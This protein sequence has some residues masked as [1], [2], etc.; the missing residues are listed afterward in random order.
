MTYSLC[1]VLPFTLR[2]SVPYFSGDSIVNSERS[3]SLLPRFVLANVPAGIVRRY[4]SPAT[5]GALSVH[6]RSLAVS[7]T[8]ETFTG[9]ELSPSPRRCRSMAVLSTRV[10][11]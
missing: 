2:I 8:K 1:G 10:N 4:F 5:Q 9:S 11:G 7:C 6:E 3:V